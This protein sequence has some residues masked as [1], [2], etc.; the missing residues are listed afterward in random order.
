MTDLEQQVIIRL[1]RNGWVDV[2]Q[3]IRGGQIEWRA[4]WARDYGDRITDV[5]TIVEPSH[6]RVLQRILEVEDEADA[7][8]GGNDEIAAEVPR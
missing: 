2:R 5:G 7:I 1:G 8:G 6:E 3:V 4:A